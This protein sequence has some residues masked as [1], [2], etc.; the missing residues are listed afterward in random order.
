M[1]KILTIL[2]FLM[3]SSVYNVFSIQTN[4]GGSSLDKGGTINGNLII[5]GQLSAGGITSS[6]TIDTACRISTGVIASNL[7]STASALSS[8]QLNIGISTGTLLGMIQ[9]TGAAVSIETNNR[10]LF[11][12][13]VSSTY[14]TLLQLNTTAQKET[15]DFNTLTGQINSTAS[16]LSS[17]QLN[18]GN[19]TGTILNL[20]GSTMPWSSN[21]TNVWSN[22]SGNVGIGT[23]NPT[24]KVQVVGNLVVNGKIYG[25]ISTSTGG[26]S[27]GVSQITAGSGISLSPAGGTGTVQIT[28]TGGGSGGVSQF[29]VYTATNPL[30]MSGYGI[31][32]SSSITFGDGKTLTTKPFR[33]IFVASSN[34]NSASKALADY[35]CTGTNDEVQIYNAINYL[36]TNNIPGTVLLSEGIFYTNAPISITNISTITI[37]GDNSLIYVNYTTGDWDGIFNFTGGNVFNCSFI[38]LKMDCSSNSGNTAR[39]SAFLCASVY[40]SNFQYCI[41]NGASTASVFIFFGFAGTFCCYDNTIS[42]CFSSGFNGQMICCSNMY[43]CKILNNT[44]KGGGCIYINGGDQNIISNNYIEQSYAEGVRF[45]AGNYNIIS[46]NIINGGSRGVALANGGGTSNYNVICGNKIYNVTTGVMIYN[47]NCNNN[48]ITGNCVHSFSDSAYSNSGG[49]Q[50]GGCNSWNTGQT[51]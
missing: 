47:I 38:N 16:A 22:K 49:T 18:I 17:F 26:A 34:A 11:Q 25:D 31:L 43:R 33:Q 46:N 30:N 7:T 12:T 44:S 40:S 10:L 32:V 6:S 21:G 51:P 36:K 42:N 45:D 27:S 19:S 14:A 41:L 1:K 8:F 2:L 50:Y 35:K 23:T 28:A 48:Q 24:S 37:Q 3:F 9:S 4:S 29:G 5:T 20:I 15:S 39:N 13:Q